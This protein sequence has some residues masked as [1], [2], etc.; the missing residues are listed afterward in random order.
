MKF[1]HHAPDGKVF[2]HELLA[3][4]AKTFAERG[5]AGQLH[6]AFDQ[7]ALVAGADQ[8]SRLVRQ[9]DFIRAIA[10]GGDHGFARGEGLREGAGQALAAGEMHE[11]IHESDD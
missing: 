3:A 9:T 10:V 2:A 1:V 4:G 5:V 6:E 7:F 8:E 11:R